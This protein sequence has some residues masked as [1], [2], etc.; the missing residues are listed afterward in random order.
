MITLVRLWYG[1][2]LYIVL[3]HVA[4]RSASSGKITYRVYGISHACDSSNILL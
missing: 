2:K 4:I 1:R 3:Y